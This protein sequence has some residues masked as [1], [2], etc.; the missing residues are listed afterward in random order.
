VFFECGENRVAAIQG[1]IDIPTSFDYVKGNVTFQGWAANERNSVA[2]VEILVDGDFIGQAQFGY[3]RPD[4]QEANPTLFGAASSG[5]RFTMDTTKL[6]N[7]RHRLTVR[8]TDSA[9]LRTEIGSVD[10]YVAN[11]SPI[12]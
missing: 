8:A 7:A 2:T 12:P 6:S 5:W 10:F 4:V 11:P 3:P 9:G 1:F